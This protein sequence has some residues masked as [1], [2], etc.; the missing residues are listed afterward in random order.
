MLAV[1]L[2]ALGLCVVL[3][4][5]R[6]GKDVP[7]SALA[8]DSPVASIAPLPDYVSNGT[9]WLLDGGGSVGVIVSFTW[10]ITVGGVTTIESAQSIIYMFKTL[11]LY[12]ITLTVM[13]NESKSDSAFTAVVSVLDSDQ[14]TL[15]DWWE[16]KYFGDLNQTAEGDFDR[17]GY[18]NLEEYARGTNPIVKDPRPT[19]VEMLKEHWGAVVLV[20]AVI[21]GA[22]LAL[23]P[24]IRK[25]QK[26]REKRKIEAA[27]AI[28]KALDE[29]TK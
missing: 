2:L 15:P 11:G 7:A 19:L 20:A 14:D 12:K 4:S 1:A 9:G 22:I 6:P 18:D 17:D 3:P 26:E 21:V 28:E 13:D 23:M 29:E 27:I 16:E 5:D 10:N 8:A 25:R 24:F